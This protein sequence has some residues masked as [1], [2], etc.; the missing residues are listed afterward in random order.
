MK[1]IIL[2]FIGITFLH[3]VCQCQIDSFNLL[4][5]DANIGVW[6]TY[7]FID[8]ISMESILNK[9]PLNV[10]YGILS[11]NENLIAEFH[12]DEKYWWIKKNYENTYRNSI[13]D[14]IFETNLRDKIS[15]LE[16]K[17]IN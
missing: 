12:T 6:Y 8:S 5:Y 9:I 13:R 3:S 7:N 15:F 11:K 16:K 17:N 4:M 2:F 14:I 1:R 10:T